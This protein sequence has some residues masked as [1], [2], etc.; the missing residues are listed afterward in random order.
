MKE[1]DV[2][3]HSTHTI[4]RIHYDNTRH[5]SDIGCESDDEYADLDDLEDE[6]LVVKDTAIA[7]EEDEPEYVF[8]GMND[9]VQF[10]RRY[11]IYLTYDK[12]YQ[13]MHLFSIDWAYRRYTSI[14]V[15]N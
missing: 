6:S 9:N 15:R 1:K 11:D 8:A 4:R 5:E 13:T 7:N 3:F 2:L 14:E 12:Y 10:T